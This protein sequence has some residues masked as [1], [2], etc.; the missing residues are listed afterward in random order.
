MMEPRTDLV[1]AA[2]AVIWRGA[3]TAPEVALVHRPKYDDWTFPKGK[4]KPGEHVING[5]LREVNEETGLSIV[6]GRALPPIHYLKDGRLKR[7]DYWAARAVGEGPIIS[8]DEVDSVR[9]FPIDEARRR[10]S[11]EWDAG[12]LRALTAAPLTTVPFIFVRHGQAGSRQEWRG[13]DERRPLD[14]IGQVQAQ[15]LA[16]VLQGYRPSLLVSSS[17]KRCSQTLKPYAA[18]HGLEIRKERLLSEP[19]YDA[20]QTLR[21]LR[22]LLD[23]G[24]PTVLCGHGKVLPELLDAAGEQRVGGTHLRKGGFAVVHRAGDRVISVERYVT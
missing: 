23:S 15:I 22:E 14:P 10:L 17:S 21:L 24:E 19:G 5:A 9:W 18:Q 3:E 13:D 4:L 2:G 7:V 20:R 8:W 16:E 6:L 11:Y 1:R 12:L